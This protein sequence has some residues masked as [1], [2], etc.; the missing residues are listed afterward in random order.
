MLTYR[1][2]EITDVKE[3]IQL[4]DTLFEAGYVH[5]GYVL[6]NIIRHNRAYIALHDNKIVGLAL[7]DK[8][9]SNIDPSE[10]VMT[11]C[12]LGVKKEYQN[13]KIATNLIKI[14][15]SR[16]ECVYLHVNFKNLNAIH[17]YEK[18]GFRKVSTL[19]NY[20]GNGSHAY[21][22]KYLQ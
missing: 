15:L 1:L 12:L 11:L 7:Y 22:M 21:Y 19:K 9:T 13:Q 10:N 4:Q 14:S 16:Y 6:T 20:Y 17:L 5:D 3:L 18:V 2:A 8:R